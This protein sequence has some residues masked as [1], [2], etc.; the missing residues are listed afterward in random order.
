MVIIFVSLN[1]CTTVNPL[2]RQHLDNIR[3]VVLAKLA[4]L[5]LNKFSGRQL[6]HDMKCSDLDLQCQSLRR[7][8]ETFFSG[9]YTSH[10][11]IL[12]LSRPIKWSSEHRRQ[13]R[14]K[15]VGGPGPSLW[16]GAPRPNILVSVKWHLPTSNV[17]YEYVLFEVTN[18][19]WKQLLFLKL[20]TTF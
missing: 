19:L 12:Y 1:V 17:V 5:I 10:N 14:I 18:I 11:M 8:Q 16:R 15:V 20:N 9:K 13:G 2:S 4:V 7:K 6:W 3:T